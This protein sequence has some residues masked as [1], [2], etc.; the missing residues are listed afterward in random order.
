MTQLVLNQVTAQRRLVQWLEL[1]PDRVVLEYD[2]QQSTD[3]A[4][5]FYAYEEEEYNEGNHVPPVINDAM[6]E[7]TARVGSAF[8]FETNRDSL[9]IT[10][11]N[12]TASEAQGLLEG[13]RRHKATLEEKTWDIKLCVICLF[14]SFFAFCCS[15]SMLHK[16]WHAYEAPWESMF[17][18]VFYLF[19][20]FGDWVLATLGLA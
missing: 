11:R 10:V 5:H 13:F 16:H 18:T 4:M 14:A 3:D 2:S 8:T 15:M 1:C 12:P 9:H 17:D 6:R 19:I 20:H 7:A